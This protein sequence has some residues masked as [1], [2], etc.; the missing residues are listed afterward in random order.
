VKRRKQAALDGHNLS[1]KEPEWSKRAAPLIPFLKEPRGWDEL[2]AWGK[3]HRVT[4]M[5]L[6]AILAWLS[7]NGFV[8]YAPLS[9]K[10]RVQGVW[11]LRAVVVEEPP[12]GM[13][14]PTA[15]RFC[16]GFVSK[17]SCLLCGRPTAP[18]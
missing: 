3:E 9:H 12:T 16:G 14:D 7:L 1:C 8:E 5:M 10:G 15:C 17:G 18:P 4:E 13:N 11:M 2:I 6:R